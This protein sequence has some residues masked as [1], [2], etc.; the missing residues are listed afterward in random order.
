MFYYIA[1]EIEN[2]MFR[3]INVVYGNYGFS[4]IINTIPE[5]F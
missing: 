4:T 2:I 5:G 1:N 3:D